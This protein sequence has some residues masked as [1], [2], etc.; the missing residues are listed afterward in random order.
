MLRLRTMSRDAAP[1]LT[2]LL[3]QVS[4]SFYTTLWILPRSVR[5]QISLA[6]LLA[7]ATDTIADTE[8][9]V[10][11]LG[12]SPGAFAQFLELLSVIH[13]TFLYVLL[14]AT[15]SPAPSHTVDRDRRFRSST[16]MYNYSRWPV[17]R[18]PWPVP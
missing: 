8:L 9:R 12:F 3:K 2:T 1:L 16:T 6:Y 10:G 5:S 14:A 4:R 13:G 7:R 18:S 17:V 15:L 11:L